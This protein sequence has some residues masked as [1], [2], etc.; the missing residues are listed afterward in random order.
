MTVK[1]LATLFLSFGLAIALAGQTLAGIGPENVVVVVN[2]KSLISRTVANHYVHLRDIPIANVILLDDVPTGLAMTLEDFKAKI[3]KPVLAE[4]DARKIANHVRVIAYSADFP[5]AV[6]VRSDIDKLPA[7]GLKKIQLPTASIT[8]VTSLYQF[9][10]SDNPSYI[11]LGSNL[12]AR[13]N[14]D[15]HFLN[16]FMDTERR[17][18]FNQA[19]QDLVDEKFAEAGKQFSEIFEQS[20]TQAPIA[21]MAAE[22]YASA[23]DSE[24]AEAMLVK[25]L[26]AGWQSAT[27]LTRSE[28]LGPII[29]DEKYKAVLAQLSDHPLVAQ[30][31]VGFSGD[32]AWM[33]N[34]TASRESSDGVRYL[35]SCMLGVVHAR[36]NTLEEA[37][38]VLQRASTA[39][40]TYPDANFWFS[41]TADV[42]TT[43]RKPG[44]TDALLWLGHGKHKASIFRKTMPSETDDCVGLMLGT[45]TMV[46]LGKPFT[47]VPGAISENLTSYSAAFG[48]SSQTKMTELLQA[49]AAMTSGPVAEPFALQAKF[50]VPMMYGYYASGVSAIEAFY[51]SIQSPYQS[52]IVGDPITQP[53]ARPPR[54]RFNFAVVD[55]LTGEKLLR[56][57]YA[58]DNVVESD[59]RTTL[60]LVELYIDGKLVR[61]LPPMKSIE[62]GVAGAPPG[63]ME[64]RTAVVGNDATQPRLSQSHWMKLV[65]SELV[66]VGSVSSDGNSVTCKA[67]GAE[68]IEWRLFGRELESTDGETSAY[69]P[70]RSVLGSGPLLLQPWAIKGE[71]R[72]PGQPVVL[73]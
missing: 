24:N 67:I 17:D 3:L 33:G 66:P 1:R 31:P 14:M 43:T 30:G 26:K 59:R 12:Y 10:L 25:A 51:L 18:K 28:T 41:L 22:A 16:P 9:V 70:D 58:P 11:D 73:P 46:L 2:A 20:P 47:F 61:V 23:E 68:R 50:P 15:R 56:L 64:L 62:M 53:F 44:M 21:I 48:T 4:V 52:L 8:G 37:V 54:G 71:Q 27:Y 42:R 45:P 39:D 38:E 7:D 34:G 35:L 40:R 55:K 63:F 6:D 49:G 29:A 65:S 36:G 13:G 19:K 69:T 32:V 72:I 5:T 57:S 60:G